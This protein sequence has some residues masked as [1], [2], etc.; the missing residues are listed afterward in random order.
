MSCPREKVNHFCV[1]C[2]STQSFAREGQEWK[3]PRCGMVGSLQGWCPCCKRGTVQ[4]ENGVLGVKRCLRCGMHILYRIT[5]VC[6]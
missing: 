4:V 6:E 1:R 3:C 5:Q 2:R